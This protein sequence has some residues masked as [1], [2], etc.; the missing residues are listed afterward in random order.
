MRS[1]T[2][3]DAGEARRYRAYE[4]SEEGWKQKD[5]ARALGVSEA[6]VSQWLTRA[7]AE[8]VEALR[9]RSI[10]GPTPRLSAEQLAEL[11]A[12]LEKGA[13]AFGFTGD[14]WTRGRIAV[15]IERE[16]GVRYSVR[17]V[18]R[19]MERIGWSRQKPERHARQQDPEKV[20]RFKT[21]RWAA[22][23]RGS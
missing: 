17:N 1:R 11:P 2:T 14:V 22:L 18:T 9:S 7:A 6:A 4:L 10:P 23:K 20:E 16:L 3:R 19:V 5:I 8:G 21:Q 15:V 13:P 12:L